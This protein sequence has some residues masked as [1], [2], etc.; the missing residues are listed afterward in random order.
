MHVQSCCFANLKSIAFSPL[1]L[2]SASSLIKLPNIK[3]GTLAYKHKET[4]QE[5]YSR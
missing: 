4:K 2:P 1:S 5:K 3:T